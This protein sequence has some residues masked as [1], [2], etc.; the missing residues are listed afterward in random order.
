M[1]QPD[2]MIK[3]GGRY[4]I[5]KHLGGGGFGQTYLAEDTHL[6]GNPL[7]VVKHLKP[8]LSDALVWETAHRLFE[9]EAQ[10]LYK[11][12]EHS[13]IPRLL[14][15][16]EEHQEFYLVQEFI[17]GE[18][19]SK[20]LAPSIQFSESRVIA[21]L[22]DVLQ[23]L[24]YIHQHH[25]IHRDLKPSNLIR[26]KRDSR[27]V[28]IDFG[29]VKQLSAQVIQTQGHTTRTIA[30]GSPGY[31]PSEQ[32]AGKPRFCSDLYA[33][34]MIGIQALTGMHP[35]EL[36]EDAKTSELIWRDRTQVSLEF[37]D[38]LDKMI[39]YDFRQRY[40]SALEVLADLAP[41]AIARAIATPPLPW[42]HT[43]YVGDRTEIEAPI[44]QSESNSQTTVDIDYTL[45]RELLAAQSWRRADQVTQRLM[46]QVC[47]REAGRLRL[48][49]IRHF[50]CDALYM[51]N[52]LW[53]DYSNGLFG[54]SMQKE[55]WQSVGGRLDMNY[56][57][58]EQ[59]SSSRSKWRVNSPW[60][61]FGNRVGWRI[62]EQWLTHDCLNFSLDAVKGH[63]PS[64]QLVSPSPEKSAKS[65]VMLFCRTEVCK[66]Y[67]P[68]ID[69]TQKP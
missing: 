14:A 62:K 3:L 4:Q 12:N 47:G 50:P 46:V 9:T 45:L 10:V 56:E 59:F 11:L 21:L 27:I 18:N 66:P 29:A 34:G 22:Q 64:W 55:I 16:F 17:A 67:V 40:Q 23:V 2:D 20:E 54:F 68:K 44:K 58:W 6:P 28:V 13:Q 26:R 42:S 19:L 49:E 25:L 5:I 7:C 33:I 69:I 57:A 60:H 43:I 38:L 31:M 63:L 39:R 24:V 53:L 37:A 35:K 8:K 48:E 32:M 61:R 51:I 1:H 52:Y 30:I 65:L 15:H 36:P 41:L